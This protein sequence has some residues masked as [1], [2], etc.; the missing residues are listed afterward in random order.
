MSEMWRSLWTVNRSPG[1]T[2]NLQPFQPVNHF[3][4]S[5]L[6]KTFIVKMSEIGFFG[7]PKNASLVKLCKFLSTA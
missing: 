5:D 7:V 6:M 1:S 2:I 3:L 4:S